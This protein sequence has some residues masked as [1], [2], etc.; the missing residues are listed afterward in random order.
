MISLVPNDE[1]AARGKANGIDDFF[2]RVNAFRAM[3]HN[4][5]AAGAAY[6]MLDALLIHGT[7]SPIVRELVILR[8]GWRTR[9]EYEFC[10]HVRVASQA[11]LSEEKILGVRDPDSCAAFSESE[12]AVMRMV[13]E[14]LER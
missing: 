2:S 6:R 10:Q 3:L 9:S 4:P 13:D 11:G 8:T 14:L 12:R 1:A 7:L 5:H